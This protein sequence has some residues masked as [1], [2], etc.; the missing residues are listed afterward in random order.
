RAHDGL[1]GALARGHLRADGSPARGTRGGHP[2]RRGQLDGD[3]APRD[4]GD[5]HR[6]APSRPHPF[7]SAANWVA[8]SSLYLTS[9]SRAPISRANRLIWVTISSVMVA[10]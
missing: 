10:S 9:P 3:A 7:Q 4:R 5:C 8:T 2:H 6:L 1:H